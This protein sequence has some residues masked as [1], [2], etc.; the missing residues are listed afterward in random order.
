MESI[1]EVYKGRQAGTFVIGQLTQ[2]DLSY[3]NC[4]KYTTLNWN[5]VSVNLT[6]DLL[7]NT[8]KEYHADFSH[9]KMT[10]YPGVQSSDMVPLSSK[11]TCTFFPETPS[12]VANTHTHKS[13]A[14]HGECAIMGMYS[15]H[16][17]LPS[18]LEMLELW[19]VGY[20]GEP[21][22]NSEDVP[23]ISTCIYLCM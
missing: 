13:A 20:W 4:I 12:Q 16:R 8:R 19:K 11:A 7:E 21:H 23:T 2:A 15:Q 9:T 18:I 6:K 5:A 17:Y 22:T 14:L 10:N 3:P 1:W